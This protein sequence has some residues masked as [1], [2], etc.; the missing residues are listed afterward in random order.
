[1]RTVA[2]VQARMGSSRL[3]G[4]VLADLQG[5]T[6]LSRVVDRLRR[7]ALL[8]QIVIATSAAERD[9]AIVAE[10][11]RI[12]VDCSRG[13][14]DDVLDRYHRCAEAHAAAA[15]V[16]ITADCPL[17][18]PEIVDA[19]IRKFLEYPCDYAS[20]DFYPRG[21]DVEVF[22]MAAL[23]RAW[24]EARRSYER[25][26]VTPYIYE[27]PELFRLVSIRAKADYS[28]YRWT[29]D[30]VED[31][32]FLR[33]VYA[34]LRNQDDFSWRDVLQLMQLEPLLAQ[35]NEHVVQKAIHA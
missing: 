15:V 25:E 13:S 3:P 20:D 17:I 14:E 8:Q 4:K 9:D 18:D 33:T 6:V 24:R 23:T 34:R 1:M 35:I 12:H 32:E 21:L 29:L 2:I 30:T 22:T 5:K 11:K 19:V 26:H 31:L 27:H 28:R 10:C 16:R 7:A